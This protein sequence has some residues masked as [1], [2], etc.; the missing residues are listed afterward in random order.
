MYRSIIS[1][2]HNLYKLSQFQL[3]VVFLIQFSIYRLQLAMNQNQSVESSF[4][5]VSQVWLESESHCESVKLL[6]PDLL[7]A[8]HYLPPNRLIQQSKKDEKEERARKRELFL[9]QRDITQ[10]SNVRRGKLHVIPQTRL[11]AVEQYVQINRFISQSNSTYNAYL[12]RNFQVYRAATSKAI[13]N[14]RSTRELDVARE[15]N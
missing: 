9:I 11:N 13:R 15:A 7:H 3:T 5:S 1:R 8:P 4:Y 2:L 10:E 14:T 6:L 12:H